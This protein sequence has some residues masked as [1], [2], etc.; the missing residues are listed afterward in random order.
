MYFHKKNSRQNGWNPLYTF[1]DT[2]LDATKCNFAYFA[3]FYS[4][5]LYKIILN[6]YFYGA[7]LRQTFNSYRNGHL[8]ET[9]TIQF[10]G[11]SFL[12]LILFAPLK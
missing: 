4:K 5:H 7:F 3:L 6:I 2:I 12:S 1:C 8:T 11:F 10:T 9:A